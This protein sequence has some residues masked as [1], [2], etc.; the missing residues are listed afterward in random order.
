MSRKYQ[1]TLT[2][3][4]RVAK[5]TIE[6]SFNRPDGF[7]FRAGQYIQLGVP[8]LL[9]PDPEGSSRVMSI[10]SS[11]LSHE[12]ICVAFRDTGSGFKNTLKAL[13]IGAPAIIEGPYGFFTLSEKP[14][15]PIVFIAG[16]IGVTPYLSM[17]QYAAATKLDVTI[18][19]LYAN[20]SNESAAYIK[21]L[22]ELSRHSNTIKLKSTIGRVD[23]HFLVNNV[24]NPYSCVWYISGPLSMVAAVRNLL[25]LLGID[26]GQIC[27]EEF[28]GY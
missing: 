17:L 24:T 12:E 27:F 9:Y 6:V 26:E 20:S 25:F 21:E 8:Q 28:T 19:L 2:G 11:P 7:Y 18:T 3:K 13:N 4:K 16:G 1:T 22:Q 5:D 14:S 10:A 23:E 15:C